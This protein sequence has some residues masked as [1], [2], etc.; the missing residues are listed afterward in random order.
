MYSIRKLPPEWSKA[1]LGLRMYG[2]VRE[3]RLSVQSSV[4]GTPSTTARRAEEVKRGKEEIEGRRQR[5]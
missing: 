1:N 5:V 3:R 4:R 2:G